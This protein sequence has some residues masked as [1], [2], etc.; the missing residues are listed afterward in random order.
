MQSKALDHLTSEVILKMATG[1][2]ELAAEQSAISKKGASLP[3]Q[4]GELLQQKMEDGMRTK[5]LA[6]EFF[7]QMDKN[8][9]G[10]ISKMEFRQ[11]M[12]ELGL[13]GKEY[14]AADCDS[15]FSVLDKDGG[16]D[17]D[18]HEI[19]IGLKSLQVQAKKVA[20]EGASAATKANELL[21]KA[22]EA[23]QSA[24]AVEAWEAALN[25]SD[26]LRNWS[27]AWHSAASAELQLGTML[28][29]SGLKPAEIVSGWDAAPED[30]G[31]GS[32]NGGSFNGSSF[33]GGSFKPR[34]GVT[35][36]T[37]NVGGFGKLG[38]VD[39]DSFVRNM[40]RLAK[41]LKT[42]DGPAMRREDV[43]TVFHDLDKSGEGNMDEAA[44]KVALRVLMDKVGEA[45][46]R[47]RKHLKQLEFDARAAQLEV[48]E[49]QELEEK[50]AEEAAS[51]EAAAAEVA[52]AEVEAAKAAEEA[53]RAAK[54]AREAEDIKAF[55]EKVAAK[56][57]GKKQSLAGAPTEAAAAAAAVAAV[58]EANAGAALSLRETSQP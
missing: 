51:A 39:K 14:G 3:S 13:M 7:A 47:E 58:A 41:E 21:E 15:L 44:L 52:A 1:F 28:K 23:R 55:E 17:L 30:D 29:A 36:N 50:R 27:T 34:R 53:K 49:R 33:N 6:K 42:G 48:K 57:R 38:M 11:T 37:G 32:F 19:T 20:A 35:S 2:E 9:D 4:L 24:A 40:M 8:G 12:R 56:R 18:L 10:A 25:N 45:E 16:G 43:V 54:A 22:A 46:Q 26:V 5:E 31:D